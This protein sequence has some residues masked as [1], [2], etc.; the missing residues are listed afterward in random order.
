MEKGKHRIKSR[1]IISL[2][3]SSAVLLATCF[4]LVCSVASVRGVVLQGK[5]YDTESQE[6]IPLVTIRVERTG[7]SMVANEEGQYRLQL[8]P[9]TYT[10]TFSHVAYYAKTITITVTDSTLTRDVSLYPALIE[11][12]GTTVFTRAYDPGQEIIVKA[13]AHKE[14]LLKQLHDYRFE[15]YTKLIMQREVKPDSFVYEMITET[16]LS[17]CWEQPDKYKEI[18]TARRQSS[19]VEAEQNL[20]TIGSILNFNRDRL[21]FLSYQIVS[22]TA[23]DALN[24][25]NYYLLDTLYLGKKPVFKLEIEPKNTINHLFQGTILI[26]DSSFAVVGVDVTMNKGLAD[27]IISTLHYKQTYAEFEDSI[28]MPI[29]IRADGLLRVPFP[30]VP[31]FRF[32]YVAALHNY[33][34][35]TGIPPH[36]FDYV[37][38]VA[39]QVDDNDTTQWQKGQL[40]PL[41]EDEKAG[42]AYIDSVTHQPKSISYYLLKYSYGVIYA[43]S[44]SS[45]YNYFHFNRVEGPYLGVGHTFTH[46]IPNTELWLRTGYAFDGKFWQHRYYGAYT[47]SRRPDITIGGGYRDAIRSRPVIMTS[48]RYNPT[49]LSLT[50]KIDPFDYY[51]E[52]GFDLDAVVHFGKKGTVKLQYLDVNQYRVRNN[53]DYGMLFNRDREHRANPEIVNGKLRSIELSLRYDSRNFMLNKGREQKVFTFPFTVVETGIETANPDIIDNDFTFQ[54]YYFWLYHIRRLPG[55]GLFSLYLYAGASR[56][57]LPPQRYFTV[58]FGSMGRVSAVDFKTLGRNN[59]SGDRV[60]VMYAMQD[61]GT[62]LFER[63]RIPLVKKIPFS[64]FVYGG[65]FWTKFGNESIRLN[66][67]Q[68]LFA[69][70]PYSEIGFGV[71]RLPMFL[72]FF[73]TWQLSDYNTNHFSFRFSMGY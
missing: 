25:Y 67:R 59:F 66:E 36:T 42:Y 33:S 57:Q 29:E 22:P 35:N 47:L 51:L 19:N 12:P 52:K 4:I 34:F 20:V 28:W 68:L 26:A 61:F 38:E 16:Q 58:D 71:G 48:S 55:A 49:F 39:E 46:L 60:L 56:D 11:L 30:G 32:N 54:R 15:A 69:A 21:D 1:V 13:I 10:V 6:T 23:H 72:K 63:S 2:Y 24:Y 37:L 3:R 14:A 31:D 50:A 65:A 45:T 41:T 5:V 18:L 40:V 64:L 70:K 8:Q 53:T 62:T 9:G 44:S 7:Q 27:I 43:L 17:G 73:F